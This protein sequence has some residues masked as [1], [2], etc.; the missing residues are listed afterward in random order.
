M[1]SER[2]WGDPAVSSRLSAPWDAASCCRGLVRARCTVLRPDPE[3]KLRGGPGAVIVPTVPRRHDRP[4]APRAAVSARRELRSVRPRTMPMKAWTRGS[5]LSTSHASPTV[6]GGRSLTGRYAVSLRW[7]SR[8]TDIGTITTPVPAATTS[9][10][11]R[12]RHRRPVQLLGRGRPA[13]GV[14][15]DQLLVRQ[16]VEGHLVDHG[17][18]V[19]GPDDG[20]RHLV[21]QRDAV[22]PVAVDRQPHQA[23]VEARRRGARPPAPP[24]RPAPARAGS[25][26]ALAPGAGP[27]CRGS[28]RSRSRRGR[29]GGAQ[30]MVGARRQA[31]PCT[32]P[33]GLFR[34]PARAAT[35]AG[36]SRSGASAGWPCDERRGQPGGVGGGGL[37]QRE[38][39]NVTGPPGGCHC[40]RAKARRPRRSGRWP[41]A[42]R[43]SPR[44]RRSSWTSSPGPA[45]G[46]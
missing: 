6:V 22:Q 14:G 27:T 13:R 2:L 38:L 36:W 12:D 19:L 45:P 20:D 34:D 29:W 16:V 23:H 7:C 32:H 8:A 42:G 28:R 31:S 3:I 44:G 15:E 1:E 10:A 46:A 25:R 26:A 39:D 35:L 5:S 43:S 37:A 17:D 41:P 24:A 4:R 33:D 9:T 30:H 18:D 40:P 21:V 11:S